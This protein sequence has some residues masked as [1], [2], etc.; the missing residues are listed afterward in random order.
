MISNMI[1]DVIDTIL[2]FLPIIVGFINMFLIIT[3]IVMIL[4]GVSI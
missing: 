1:E 4:F 2:M 3:L